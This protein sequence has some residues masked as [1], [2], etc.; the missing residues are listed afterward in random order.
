MTVPP[1]LFKNPI[2]TLYYFSIVLYNYAKDATLY[3]SKYWSILATL[4]LIIVA[5]RFVQGFHSEVVLIPIL[6]VC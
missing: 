3:L 5:P 1:T 4:I 6:I 2:T